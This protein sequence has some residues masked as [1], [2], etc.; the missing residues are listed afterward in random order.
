MLLTFELNNFKSYNE[1]YKFNF[2]ACK[3]HNEK[4]DYVINDD[5]VSGLK[6]NLI[7]GPHGT[8]KSNLIQA[9]KCLKELVL[10][11]NSNINA[12]DDQMHTNF[13]INFKM[14]DYFYSYDIEVKNDN[15]GI[16]VLS[17][18]LFRSNDG[19]RWHMLFGRSF[20]DGYEYKMERY[21]NH[22]NKTNLIKNT[23][24]NELFL[25]KHAEDFVI[26]EHIK[27]WF[28][29]LIIFENDDNDISEYIRYNKEEV[30]NLLDTM[31]L[32]LNEIIVGDN[33]KLQYNNI[34]IDLVEESS[35][36]QKL[37]KLACVILNVIKNNKV[38]LIDEFQLHPVVEQNIVDKFN[39]SSAQLFLV[40]NNVLL[41]DNLRPDQIYFI[42]KKNNVADIFSLIDF[43]H[44]KG[45]VFSKRYLFGRY[46]A[47]P[48]VY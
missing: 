6:S 11:N 4:L 29:D 10:K 32:K 3:K 31:G 8:G 44:D 28:S 16:L 26:L 36:I 45:N 20:N 39:E 35:G 15:D 14:H 7:Y 42:D 40:T 24:S 5:N 37:V 25:Y 13:V 41:M 22:K 34:T 9:I 21:L 46:G 38:L 47:T 30:I 23:T 2:A 12:F 1:N 33:I 19:K 27:Q 43:K 18:M 48:Y 17:E